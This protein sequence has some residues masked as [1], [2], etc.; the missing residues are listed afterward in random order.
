[1]GHQK[2]F[3][4]DNN[5]ANFNDKI[6]RAKEAVH[7]ILG[8]EWGTTFYKKFLLKKRKNMSNNVLS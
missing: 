5:V 3:L 2:W 8:N 6:T 7:T 1:M 4:I